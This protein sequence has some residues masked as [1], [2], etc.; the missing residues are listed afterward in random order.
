M[1]ENLFPLIG[2]QKKGTMS[3]CGNVRLSIGV[4]INLPY[5]LG[6]MQNGFIQFNH[7]WSLTPRQK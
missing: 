2:T 3:V 5:D 6:K 4:K 1:K 7:I